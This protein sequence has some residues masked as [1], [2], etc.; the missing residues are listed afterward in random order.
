MPPAGEPLFAYFFYWFGQRVRRLAG[1]D[2]PVLKI[3]KLR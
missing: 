3:F 1:R 2:P